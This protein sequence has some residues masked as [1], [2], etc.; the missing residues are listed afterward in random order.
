MIN[1]KLLI[2]YAKLIVKVGANVQKNQVVVIN[3]ILEAQPLTKL[4]VE[5]A[6][7]AGAK[8]VIVH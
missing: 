3:S 4:V 2:E 6:Y 8:N 7:L 1:T 5:Q